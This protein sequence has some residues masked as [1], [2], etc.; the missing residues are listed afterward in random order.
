M[1]YYRFDR[2]A[3]QQL[4][5]TEYFKYNASVARSPTF[6]NLREVNGRFQLKPGFIQLNHKLRPK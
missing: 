3:R 1:K 5:T 2:N 4:L 6:I